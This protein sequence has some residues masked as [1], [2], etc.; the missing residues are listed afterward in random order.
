MTSCYAAATES[1]ANVPDPDPQIDDSESRHL[2]RALALA[3]SALV[4]LVVC[5]KEHLRPGTEPS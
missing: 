2:E 4:L 3:F 5:V 1:V